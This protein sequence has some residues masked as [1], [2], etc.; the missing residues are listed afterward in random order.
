MSV[1]MRKL[2]V[3]RLVRNCRNQPRSVYH[4]VYT[5]ICTHAYVCVRQDTYIYVCTYP[6]THVCMH[7]QIYIG[8]LCTVQVYVCMYTHT[9]MCLD[10]VK[11]M[12]DNNFTTLSTI[13]MIL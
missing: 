1:R 9:Y 10:V 13:M 8:M 3:S 12:G 6:C 2:S 5:Y 11:V 4:I 7:I